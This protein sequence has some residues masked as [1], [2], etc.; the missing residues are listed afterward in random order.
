MLASASKLIAEPCARTG[1]RRRTIPRALF[2]RLL[3]VCE[4]L[5]EVLSCTAFLFG[6]QWLEILSIHRT[7]YSLHEALAVSIFIAAL[8]AAFLNL[9][10]AHHKRTVVNPI[11]ETAID[12]RASLQ[13]LIFVLMAHLL[14]HAKLPYPAILIALLLTPAALMLQR[15]LFA[16]VLR[17]LNQLRWGTENVVIYGASP[18]G[19][20][21]ASAIQASPRLA[22]VAVAMIDDNSRA[23]EECRLERASR[24][25]P[26]S[27][28]CAPV[29]PALLQ[30]FQ[31]DLLLVAATGLSAEQESGLEAAAAQ[32][33][34][35][36]AR[37]AQ[38]S[39]HDL[40]ARELLDLDDLFILQKIA[41]T[42]PDPYVWGKRALD[43]LA[44]TMLLILLCPFFIIIALLIRLTSHGPALFVHKRVGLN[45]HL[46]GMY[47]FRS[48][49]CRAHPYEHSP[50]TTHDPRITTV[51]RFLRRTSIDELPQLINVLRGE[52]SLVGPR[53]EM[54]FIT[55]HYDEQQ[56]KRLQVAPGITGLWQLSG[57]RSYPIHEN[58]HHDLFYIRHRCL[59]LDL[60]ILLHT[61]F[62]GMR[63][64]V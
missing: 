35:R 26:L 51:G 50:T 25:S 30:S 43:L 4:V 16:V 46:F 47:K 63:S 55:R 3:S 12:I 58:L 13:T 17:R 40:P 20:R 42:T 59:T 8:T 39:L 29:T 28:E 10:R 9:N 11:R 48:M 5:A 14:L 53:P 32:A 24:D 23:V 38:A 1:N 49:S 44:S 64:G 31:C 19:Q 2:L 62:F 56:Q 57:D 7:A 27:I 18:I 54:P 34:S 36:I 22:I 21:I 37:L 45:G 52:M 41:T 33:G 61:L 15:C 6:A 60:A